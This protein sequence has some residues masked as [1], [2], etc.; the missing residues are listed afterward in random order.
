MENKNI[1]LYEQILSDI[2]EFI[3]TRS[4]DILRG[5]KR[6]FNMLRQEQ[7]KKRKSK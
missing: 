2:K 7:R 5:L 3:N 1:G 4:Q 6:K